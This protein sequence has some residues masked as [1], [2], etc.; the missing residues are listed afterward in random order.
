VI[1]RFERQEEPEAPVDIETLD[2]TSWALQTFIEGETAT[3]LMAGTT[4]TLELNDGQ[5]TGSAGCNSYG[6]SYTL[7]EG[8]IT[9]SDLF[10][11]EMACLDP[12]G[13]ME[14]EQRYLSILNNVSTFDREASRLTLRT[15]DGRG[16]VFTPQ[17]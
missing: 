15:P 12:E 8:E 7:Q 11:T 4:V 14:Q 16:L 9:F 13:V 2:G 1:L 6:G 5:I 10:W 17:P 3:S